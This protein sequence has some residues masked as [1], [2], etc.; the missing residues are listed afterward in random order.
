VI[1]AFALPQTKFDPLTKPFE[2]KVRIMADGFHQK[3]LDIKSTYPPTP[4]QLRKLD[5]LIWQFRWQRKL[6]VN[7]GIQTSQER[8]F[9]QRR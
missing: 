3:Y 4:E 1:N 8:F 5:W 2:K 6:V 7:C 9:V